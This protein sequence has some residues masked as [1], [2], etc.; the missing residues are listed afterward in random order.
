MCEDGDGVSSSAE[1]VLIGTGPAV[2][3]ESHLEKLY[4]MFRLTA[5]HNGYLQVRKAWP[6]RRILQYLLHTSLSSLSVQSRRMAQQ[7]VPSPNNGFICQCMD[8][9]TIQRRRAL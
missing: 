2:S 5:G 1:A 6:S 3:T 4:T 7:P 8:S 9:A